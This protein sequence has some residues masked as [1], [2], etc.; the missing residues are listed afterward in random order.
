MA[1]A[2]NNSATGTTGGGTTVSF[3]YAVGS[4]A[5]RYLLIGCSNF[6]NLDI[7][8]VTYNSVACSS[9]YDSG[10]VSAS[11]EIFG[12]AAPASGTNTMSFTLASYDPQGAKY[13]VAD[14]TG[15]DQTTPVGSTVVNTGNSSGPVTTGSVTCPSNGAIFGIGRHTYS[16][17][18]MTIAAGTSIGN[19]TAGANSFAGA[20]SLSTG[21]LSWT[22][23]NS[24]N[25]RAVGIPIN[26]LVV[27]GMTGGFTL[28]DF[29][30]SGTF[31]T[32]AL[33]QLSGGITLDDF[34]LSGFLGLAPG[35]IDTQPF[36]NWAGT[37]LPGVTVPNVVFLKLDRTLPLALVNQVTAGDAVMTITNAALVTGTYYI[38]VSYD[39]TGANVG[40]ELVLA[41]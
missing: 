21:A 12:L 18:G 2:L 17:A 9:V 36:K 7:S 30:L 1:V 16:S 8:S 13:S 38:M 37:L 41:T 23:S 34:A 29:T 19:T 40:A 32:G 4:G 28:D 14:W 25:W 15:V 10:A 22:P 3:S 24:G 26:P 35:R 20:Y 27:T 31:A 39:A 6:G 11:M 33:S 5:D